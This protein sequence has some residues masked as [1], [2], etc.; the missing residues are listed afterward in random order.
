MAPNE[1]TPINKATQSQ[2][3][4]TFRCPNRRRIFL[5]RRKLPTLRLGGKKSGRG[6]SLLRMLRKVRLRWLKLQYWCMLKKL[7]EYYSNLIKDVIEGGAILDS[8]QQRLG[9]PVMAFNFYPS[10]PG[11]NRPRSVFM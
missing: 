10:V 1:E 2:L 3:I 8:Y 6:V 5:R 4:T 9:V 7:K 11:P